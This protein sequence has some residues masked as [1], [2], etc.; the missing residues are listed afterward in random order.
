MGATLMLMN[1]TA[2][3]PLLLLLLLPRHATAARCHM[4]IPS[5]D[6]DS[7]GPPVPKTTAN[8]K[9]MGV[10][11]TFRELAENELNNF[12]CIFLDANSTHRRLEMRSADREKF[13]VVVPPELNSL[14]LRHKQ[15]PLGWKKGQRPL[16]HY[17]QGVRNGE[18]LVQT[19]LKGSTSS[20][21]ENV[22]PY[23][24]VVRDKVLA[25]LAK[26][27]CV[28]CA[29]EYSYSRS[30]RGDSM[31]QAQVCYKGPIT[32]LPSNV[33]GWRTFHGES[34]YNTPRNIRQTLFQIS[35]GTYPTCPHGAHSR[36]SS[37]SMIS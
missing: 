37:S 23:L 36:N 28:V 12:W 35:T 5:L 3:R 11:W 14:Q 29:A 4:V 17:P 15:M 2:A 18:A 19:I 26:E 22:P 20:R 6:S 16:P 25:E 9:S 1:I 8:D 24:S 13:G 31:T 21:F 34:R 10:R 33:F 30:V 32:L 27:V 7:H